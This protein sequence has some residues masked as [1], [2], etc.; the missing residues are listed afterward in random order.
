MA[1]RT[2]PHDDLSAVVFSL[3]DSGARRHGRSGVSRLKRAMDVVGA[4]IGLVVLAIPMAVTGVLIRV[5]MGSPVLF[6]QVRPGL[7]GKPFTLYKFRTMCDAVD[8]EGRLLADAERLPALGRMLRSTSLDELPELWNVLRGD[9]SLVGPRP[10]L[11]NYLDLYT[12]EQARRHHTRPGL[13]GLSQV[14][15]RNA[16]S[17]ERKL[18]LDVEYV[19]RWSLWLDIKIL[20]RTL[21]TVVRREGITQPGSAT[22]EE[23]RGQ[24]N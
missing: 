4:L 18:A 23:F 13:T 8:N 15:G 5:H 14:C 22:T 7:Y 16:Q 24:M 3:D 10:L 6:K 11:K 1:K 2:V 9:M 17:W 21:G 19:D 20:V 12:A